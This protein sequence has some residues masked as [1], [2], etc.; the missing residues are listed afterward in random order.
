MKRN[1]ML[2]VLLLLLFASYS[3]LSNTT[4][5]TTLTSESTTSSTSLSTTT[6]SSNPS[7]TTSALKANLC[8]TITQ[9]PKTPIPINPNPTT[10][11]TTTKPQNTSAIPTTTNPYHTTT[12]NWPT[13]TTNTTGPYVPTTSGNTTS[14]TTTTITT[15]TTTMLTT[16]IPQT[17][18]TMTSQ[19]NPVGK[20][21]FLLALLQMDFT[22]VF[23]IQVMGYEQWDEAGDGYD[24]Y[25]SDTQIASKDPWIVKEHGYFCQEDANHQVDFYENEHYLYYF[26]NRIIR[27]ENGVRS[28]TEGSFQFFNQVDM[29]QSIVTL[30]EMITHYEVTETVLILY[31]DQLLLESM[32]MI[33]NATVTFI[34]EMNDGKIVRMFSE[35]ISIDDHFWSQYT[36]LFSYTPF[37]ESIIDIDLSN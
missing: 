34:I 22:D 27:I 10:T 13:T 5:S 11:I 30:I 3:C 32:N 29:F 26:D 23:G 1:S 12:T 16:T 25:Y 4:Q 36:Y 14:A 2:M 21:L 17:Y 28:E 37:D 35:M 9:I 19:I 24:K 8:D 18:Y 33:G 6:S 7:Q 31:A 15:T 20:D